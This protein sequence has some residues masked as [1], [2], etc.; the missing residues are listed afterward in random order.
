MKSIISYKEQSISASVISKLSHL[1]KQF[2]LL[3]Y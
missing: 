2:L 1:M 3:Y